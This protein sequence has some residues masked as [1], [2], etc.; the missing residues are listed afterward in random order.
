MIKR[1]ERKFFPWVFYHILE[2]WYYYIGAL[3]SLWLL[4]TAQSRIPQMAKDLGD[5]VASGQTHKIEIL[6]FF[7]IAAAILVFR[8]F[9]RLLFF[10]PARVQ[11]KFLR[12]EL[13]EKLESSHPG[14]YKDYND[15]QLFQTLFNDFNRIRGMIGFALLQVGN[16]IIAMWIFVP[17]IRDFNSDLLIAFTPVV[18]TVVLFSLIIYLF[19]PF[20]KKEIMLDGEVQNLIIES[21]E[22]KQTIKNFHAE[23]SF[24]DLF[25]NKSDEALKNFFKASLGQTIASPL[26]KLGVGASLL[27]G[28][29][30]IFQENMGATSLIFFSGFLF[31]VLEP[32]LF[33]SW[34]GIVASQGYAGWGRIKKMLKDL[35]TESAEE[36]KAKSAIKSDSA[37]HLSF[38]NKEVDIGLRHEEWTVIVGETGVGKSTLLLRLSNQLTL[39]GRKF[40]LVPQEPY[41]YNDTVWNNIFLG[42]EITSEKE[43][44][45][46]KYLEV[47]G[48]DVLADDI[49]KVMNLEVGE[50]GKKV[51]GGQAKRIALIRSLVS[52]VDVFLWDDPFS[53]IDFILEREILAKIKNEE[54][55]KNKTFIL[56]SH[57]LSTVRFCNEVILVE[58]HN[59]VIERGN[60]LKLL[61]NEKSKISEYFK[62][63]MV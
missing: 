15:G 40:S 63:Q 33:M 43:A 39:I 4:H 32:L 35:E 34:I 28:A 2:F 19:Q 30:I 23:K 58:K 62:K 47:F 31:L 8:T 14:R 53:S 27:W 36:L 3:V 11:Q 16:I 10:Y 5:M 59:A 24:Y 51:S 38:W 50:N 46:K 9:S 60:P 21:Y 17:K 29:Y 45:A 56:T 54:T 57:R 7:L 26:V 52:D 55:L 42:N 12:M 1:L 61:E 41:L 18:V 13:M 37:F 20:V 44:L 22:A 6:P 49:Q 48:L 25:Y